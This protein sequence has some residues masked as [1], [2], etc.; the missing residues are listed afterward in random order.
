[1]LALGDMPLVSVDHFVS[2]AA[3]AEVTRPAISR[4]MAW[5]GPPW[6]A[7]TEW[8]SSHRQRLRQSLRQKSISLYAPEHTLLDVDRLK[9]IDRAERLATPKS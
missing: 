8:L 6:V 2:L 4:G 1:M 3:T 9:D 7:A 5:H